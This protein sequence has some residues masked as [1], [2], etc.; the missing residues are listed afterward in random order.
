M[1]G[2]VVTNKLCFVGDSPSADVVINFGA[3]DVGDNDVDVMVVE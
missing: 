3:S 2:V 1:N